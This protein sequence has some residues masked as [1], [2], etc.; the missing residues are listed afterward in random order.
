M[1]KKI[2][3][4]QELGPKL[5]SATPME[6]EEIIDELIAAT[7]QTRGS[8]LA[9]LSELD[10]AIEKSLKAGRIVKLPNGTSFR[11]IGKKD[12]RVKISLRLNPRVTNGVNSEFRGQWINAENIGKTE[13]EMIPIWN[14][15]HPDDPIEE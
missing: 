2:K 9:V 6:A 11:P 5:E 10:V 12:G 8:I 14:V 7:N 13:A 1:A 4:W 3:M 15:L